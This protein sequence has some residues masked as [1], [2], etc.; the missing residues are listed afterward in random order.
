MDDLILRFRELYRA[1]GRT[2]LTAKPGYDQAQ[3]ELYILAQALGSLYAKQ[4]QDQLNA[5][6]REAMQQLMGELKKLR[7]SDAV[8]APVNTNRRRMNWADI[9]ITPEVTMDLRL[10]GRVVDN[11]LVAK[12]NALRRKQISQILRIVGV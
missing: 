12:L 11:K 10:I 6:R 2:S 1:F 8:M 4:T 5:C 3:I 7:Y 9:Q